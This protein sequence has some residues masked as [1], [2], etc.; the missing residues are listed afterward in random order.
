MALDGALTRL[1]ATPLG[2]HLWLV[3]LDEPEVAAAVTLSAAEYARAERFVFER[4]RRRYLAAHRALRSVLIHEAG[5]RADAVFDIGAHG[6]PRLSAPGACSFNMSH[7]AHMALIGLTDSG[8][9]GVDIEVRHAITDLHDLA[10]H[11][12][13]AQEAQALALLKQEDNALT[14]F[15][16]CWTR[17]EACLKALGTGL[18]LPSHVFTTG[19]EPVEGR[20]RIPVDA[21]EAT[22][23]VTSVHV[24]VDILAATAKLI[25]LGA[26][27]SR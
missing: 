20:I 18:S 4:D 13:S 1:G 19:I 25:S 12:F 11:H 9:I 5:M 16:R 7:S 26:E 24:G 17:K 21:G 8:E 14:A 23:D 22:V 15:L 27:A 3:N 2:I 6:K 10:R